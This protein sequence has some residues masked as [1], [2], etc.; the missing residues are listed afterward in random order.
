MLDEKYFLQMTIVEN[1]KH[2]WQLL[3]LWHRMN[4]NANFFVSKLRIAHWHTGPN[5]TKHA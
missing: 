4:Y 1:S 5:H 3:K 2:L